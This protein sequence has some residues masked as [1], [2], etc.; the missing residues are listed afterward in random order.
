MPRNANRPVETKKPCPSA[1]RPSR[2]SLDTRNSRSTD[3]HIEAIRLTLYTPIDEGQKK[4]RDLFLKLVVGDQSKAQRHIFF[5][6]REAAKVPGVGKD[7][8]PR[9]IKRA[10]V[11][12]AHRGA[13]AS[14]PGRAGLVGFGAVTEA[15]F[16]A[17]EPLGVPARGVVP[18][19]VVDV[20]CVAPIAPVGRRASVPSRAR[21]TIPNV[22]VISFAAHASSLVARRPRLGGKAAST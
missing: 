1:S 5:A 3:R 21:V 7:V 4:E 15:R 13:D 14:V 17:A 10:A 18:Q 19:V 8:A 22:K 12:G 2:K 20:S 11:I 9:E 16:R 6:E